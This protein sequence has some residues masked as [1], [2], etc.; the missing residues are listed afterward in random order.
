MK[1][2]GLRAADTGQD[3]GDYFPIAVVIYGIDAANRRASLLRLQGGCDAENGSGKVNFNRTPA[4]LFVLPGRSHDSGGRDETDFGC[5]HIPLPLT[6]DRKSLENGRPK[7]S[8]DFTIGE[9][10]IVEPDFINQAGKG[11]RKTGN[12]LLSHPKITRPVSGLSDAFVPNEDAIDVDFPG[13]GCSALH[14]GNMG[15]CALNGR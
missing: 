4:R 7:Q 3:H 14:N 1:V 13:S 15:P 8:G 12:V 5:R 11:F 6:A 10:A 2:K 9:R